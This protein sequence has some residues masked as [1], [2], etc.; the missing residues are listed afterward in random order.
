MKS[1]N[2]IRHQTALKRGGKN[3]RGDSLI[4]AIQGEDAVGF[5]FFVSE[6]PTPE[7]LVEMQEQQQGLLDTLADPNH[8][9][10]AMLRLQGYSNSEIAES[11]AISVRSVERKISLI[12][13]VWLNRL[14]T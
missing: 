4:G 8:R 10:I 3:V 11:L 7:F 2:Q 1:I 9:S 5:D 12:K 13:K 14:E 6:E